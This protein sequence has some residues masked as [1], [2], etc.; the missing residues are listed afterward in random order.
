MPDPTE[1]PTTLNL[2]NP[3]HASRVPAHIGAEDLARIRQAGD[4]LPQ[5]VKPADYI[6][7]GTKG[8]ELHL[9]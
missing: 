4:A 1:A 6:A 5:V 3:K 7:E 8:F 9:D 2:P